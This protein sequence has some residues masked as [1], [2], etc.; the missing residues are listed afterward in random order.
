MYLQHQTKTGLQR[1]TGAFSTA[2]VRLRLVALIST[3][4][5]LLFGYDT[6][7]I[8]GALPFIS[9][10]LKLAPGLQGW[11]TSSL[12][13]GAAFGAVLV[14]RVSDRYGRKRLIT[15]LAGLFFLA[16]LA[17]SLAPS[18]GWLIGARMVLGLAV[19]GVSVLVPSFL[20]EIA[21]TNRRGRLVTQNELMV[22][23]G[24][25]LAFILNAVLGTNF[26]NV[27]GIW[28]WMIVL[29]VIPA[30]LLGVGTHFVPESPRWLM[31]K[32]RQQDAEDS[33][34][35][36]RTPQEVPN[37]L[38]HLKQTI[39]KS[40]EHKKVKPVDA[41]KVKW[42][43]RLLMIGIGLGVIQQIAGINVMMYYGTSILQMTGFGRNSALI[44]NIANGVTAVAATIVTM[45][46]LKHV[47]RRPL[48][49]I[50]L[51]GTSLAITGVTF[52]SR[53]PAGSPLRAFTT[54]LM[55]MLFLAFFQGAISPMTWLLMSE[56]FPEQLR[57]LGMGTATFFLWLGNFAVGVLFPIG[58]A[59]MGMFWTFV[60]F[61]VTNIVSLLFV[62]I[63][64]PETAGKSLEALHR[65]EKARLSR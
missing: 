38:E 20:A 36:L 54:I 19:G 34:A 18:A 59:Q 46:L 49:I 62:V 21:P 45:Q 26:G 5:G 63:F 23:S 55:M 9:S 27:H 7:V 61:I 29:A 47:P 14:G 13:L 17:S 43:R 48:L 35:V 6:G 4:G 40:A 57:G 12:T 51:I 24:Q 33:L 60:C 65:E 31:M 44:A 32:G 25:L 64:V 53:L 11:V 41:L 28:R 39:A 58:L 10:E 1:R 37:E 52:A 16:T 15:G 56:I 42:I 50:G 22:V 8:N 2:R 30:I 3:M